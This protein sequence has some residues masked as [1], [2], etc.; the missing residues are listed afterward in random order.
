MSKM[1]HHRETKSIENE[2]KT[3]FDVL[4]LDVCFCWHQRKLYYA[5]LC[6]TF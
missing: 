6:I 2:S 4:P 1:V 3:V 5:C